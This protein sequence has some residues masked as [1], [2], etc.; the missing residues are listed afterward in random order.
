MCNNI[1]LFKKYELKEISTRKPTSNFIYDRNHQRKSIRVTINAKNPNPLETTTFHCLAGNVQT[2]KPG[3]NSTV[4][5][6][7]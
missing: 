5:I 4:V 1:S 3:S 2:Q 7:Y 6:F